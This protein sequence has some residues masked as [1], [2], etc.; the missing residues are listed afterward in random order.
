MERVL[1]LGIVH[2]SKKGFSVPT[3][4]WFQN[5]LAGFARET[6]LASDGVAMH[7]FEK[8]EVE[9]LLQAHQ[10]RDCSG[11]IYALLVFDQWHRR[12]ARR[13]AAWKIAY[14]Q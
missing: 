12:F 2:R 11:Q 13:S 7:Y 6:L 5:E 10:T 14:C 8:T 1:P 9:K 3:R 4:S